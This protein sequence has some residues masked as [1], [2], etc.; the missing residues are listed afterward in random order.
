MK[1]FKSSLNPS[2]NNQTV[3]LNTFFYFERKIFNF[4]QINPALTSLKLFNPTEIKL[5]YWLIAVVKTFAR[6]DFSQTGKEYL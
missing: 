3:V 6:L 1:A 4:S 5:A 2:F